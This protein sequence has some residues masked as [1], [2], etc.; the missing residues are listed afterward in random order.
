MQERGEEI[1]LFEV[2]ALAFDIT[3]ASQPWGMNRR[4]TFVFSL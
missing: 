4:L 2:L 3:C 1:S